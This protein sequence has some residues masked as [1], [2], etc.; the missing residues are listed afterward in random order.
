MQY[1]SCDCLSHFKSNDNL[2]WCCSKQLLVWISAS[3]KACTSMFIGSSILFSTKK[4]QASG[5]FLF[6][7]LSCIHLIICLFVLC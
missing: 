4:F 3:Y 5:T 7:F 6:L 2:I 1:I